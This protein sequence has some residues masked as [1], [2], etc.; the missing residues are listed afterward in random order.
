MT[1]ED[2]IKQLEKRCRLLSVAMAC[3]LVAGGVFVLAAASQ[4]TNA[5]DSLQAEKLEIVDESGKVRIRLGKLK[6]GGYGLAVYD[7]EGDAKRAG[8]SLGVSGRPELKLRNEESS[9]EAAAS[10][11]HSE[12]TL[13]ESDRYIGVH[14]EASA[15]RTSRIIVQN[16]GRPQFDSEYPTR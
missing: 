4:Q 12:I 2:R 1:H 9:L 14:L 16:K 10:P 13:R 7:Q 11:Q 5:P 8:V 15:K 3:L 6:E